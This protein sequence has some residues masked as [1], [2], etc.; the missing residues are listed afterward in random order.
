MSSHDPN[1]C[2]CQEWGYADLRHRIWPAISLTTDTGL[3]QIFTG[4]H[5]SCEHWI[6]PPEELGDLRGLAPVQSVSGAL[7]IVKVLAD[8]FHRRAQ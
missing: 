8:Q 3:T 2:E 7:E 4:H 6:A 5:P 1:Q